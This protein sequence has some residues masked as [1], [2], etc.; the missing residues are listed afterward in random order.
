M[1]GDAAG[2]KYLLTKLGYSV[3]YLRRSSEG[4]AMSLLKPRV[5]TP[6]RLAANRHSAQKSTGPRS[7]RG[8]AQSRLNGLRHGFCSP[9]YR[10]FW[11]AL[12]DA[13]PGYPV[14]N[15]VCTLLT[16]EQSCH[17]VYADLIDLHFEME[18][19]DRAYTQRVRRQRARQGLLDPERSLEPIENK[20][21]RE[22]RNPR[23]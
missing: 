16:P 20:G 12:L 14:G 2:T 23:S 17:P 3:Y 19:D 13:P 21:W 22:N 6:A 8:K 15:T 5:V 10:Q 11:R 4:A 7:A 18:L 9:A 1:G